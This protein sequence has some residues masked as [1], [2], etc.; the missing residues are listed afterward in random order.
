V[1][2]SAVLFC[3]SAGPAAA[4]VPNDPQYPNQ[5]WAGK[6]GAPAAWDVTTGSSQVKV[7]V[8]DDGV[9]P[10]HADL[11]PNLDLASGHDFGEGDNNATEQDSGHGSQVASILGSRGNNAFG[12]AGL[13]WYVRII[14]VKV[15]KAAPA[16]TTPARGKQITAAAEAAGFKYAGDIGAR[17]ANASFS[18]GPDGATGRNAAQRAASVAKITAAS[19]TLFVVPAGNTSPSGSNNDLFPRYP[20]NYD[21]PN[22]ICV[23]GSDESDRLWPQ[24][25]YGANSVDLVAPAVNILTTGFSPGHPNQYVRDANDGTSYSAPM[26]SGVA[27]LY[28]ARYPN[29]TAADARRAILGGVDVNPALQGKTATGGRINA[30]RTLAIPPTAPRLTRLSLRPARFRAARSRRARRGGTRVRFRLS[31]A[32]TV[33]FRVQKPL[34][35]RRVGKRCA[36]PRR[37]NRGKRRCTRWVTLRG[38]FTRA[39]KQGRNSFK[40][41]GRLR[42]HRLR[43]GRYRLR[44]RAVNTAGRKSVP[45]TKR[46]RVVR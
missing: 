39:G 11:A 16:G 29:A 1:L 10:A 32:A 19:N 37:S 17:V 35:G 42:G 28:F 25:N 46:F 41:R 31:E 33:R 18:N 3:L 8:I 15:R 22:V 38:S 44:A 2:C 27:A 21:A 43:R 6:M 13:A 40:F 45:K 24:S 30:Q 36:R 20:C 9:N 5:Y 7:A 12:M 26:V 4:I 14:P 23:G 34:R